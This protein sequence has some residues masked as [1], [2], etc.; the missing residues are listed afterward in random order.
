MNTLRNPKVGDAIIGDEWPVYAAERLIEGDTWHDSSFPG[1]RFRVPMHDY[2][3][4]VNVTITGKT[5]TKRNGVIW[6][7]CKIEF[8]GDGEPSTF[9]GGWIRLF[10]N[11]V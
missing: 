3:I 11:E 2:N 6:Y 9:T 5:P 8:V 1:C 7:R 10:D 4:A